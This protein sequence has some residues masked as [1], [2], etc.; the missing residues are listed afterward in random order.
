MAL[1]RA[2]KPDGTADVF[3]PDG[4][5]V[6]RS[7]LATRLALTANKEGLSVGGLFH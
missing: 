1:A 4:A 2:K 6:K 5:R 3:R 7:A